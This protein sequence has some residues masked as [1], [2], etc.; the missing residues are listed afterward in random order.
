MGTKRCCFSSGQGK[1]IVVAMHSFIDI[2]KSH[3]IMLQNGKAIRTDK[4]STRAYITLKSDTVIPLS[5][6]FDKLNII[7][8]LG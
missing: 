4:K 6:I 7:I 3:G 5:F 1:S 2:Y 8:T